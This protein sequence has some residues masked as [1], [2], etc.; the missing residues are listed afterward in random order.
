MTLNEDQKGFFKKVFVDEA[1]DPDKPI[2]H[3]GSRSF[4]SRQVYDIL[5]KGSD[6]DYKELRDDLIES[7]R[8]IQKHHPRP[9]F[10]F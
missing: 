3:K 9:D 4:S 8:A 1:R 6:P 5:E 7:V 2:Y 10:P